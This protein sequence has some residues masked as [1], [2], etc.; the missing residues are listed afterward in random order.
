MAEYKHGS[1]DIS[2]QQKTFGGFIKVSLWVGG[3]SIG[4]LI[5]LAIF[6]S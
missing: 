3:I 4:A 1:M 6:N 5:F 2:A